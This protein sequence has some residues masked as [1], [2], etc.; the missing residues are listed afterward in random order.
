VVEYEY[1]SDDWFNAVADSKFEGDDCFAVDVCGDMSSGYP[2]DGVYGFQGH[3]NGPTYIR[4]IKVA[5]LPYS[6]NGAG[7]RDSLYAEYNPQ[8]ADSDP[9]LCVTR[10]GCMDE[11]YEEYDPQAVVDVTDWCRTLPVFRPVRISGTKTSIVKSQ[12]FIQVSD[13]G[14]HSITIF[15]VSGKSV[16]TIKDVNTDNAK[17]YHVSG[18]KAGIYFIR[19]KTSESNTLEKASLL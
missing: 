17:N 14:E 7:C 11:S 9:S 4:N 3:H 13:I 18:L 5:A 8:A 12:L 19:I 6:G 15:D 16:Y 1:H 2:R 10:R